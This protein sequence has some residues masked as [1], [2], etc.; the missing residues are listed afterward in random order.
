MYQ[1]LEDLP[2]DYLRNCG[3]SVRSSVDNSGIV[4]TLNLEG[5]NFTARGFIE[6]P[7]ER[8]KMHE[9]IEE[10]QNEIDRYILKCDTQI[11][12]LCY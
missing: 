4:F 1:H 7:F 8:Y 9:M 6:L 11:E 10:L 12:E 2:V 3:I 5:Y